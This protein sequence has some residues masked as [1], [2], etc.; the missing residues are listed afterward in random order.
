MGEQLCNRQ[1]AG[2]L[3]RNWGGVGGKRKQMQG[4]RKWILEGD[5]KKF[6][7]TRNVRLGGDSEDV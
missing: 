3:G 5:D 6:K 4:G 1:L 2:L 7:C